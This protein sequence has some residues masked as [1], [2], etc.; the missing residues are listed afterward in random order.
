MEDPDEAD[1]V[2]NEEHI[3][4]TVT[5]AESNTAVVLDNNF[6]L[7]CFHPFLINSARLKQ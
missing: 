5:A 3:I 1:V 7:I 4:G 2:K 6:D